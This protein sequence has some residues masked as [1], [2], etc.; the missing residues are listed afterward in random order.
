MKGRIFLGKGDFIEEVKEFLKEKEPI[1]E[2]PRIE[3]FAGR[4]ALRE[5]FGEI[6]KKSLDEERIYVAD[7]RYGYTLREM[8]DFL[9]VHY[10]TVSK[11]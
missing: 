4:P 9:R 6:K 3:R 1:K 11:P 7:V 5:M 2:I 10:S 8:G